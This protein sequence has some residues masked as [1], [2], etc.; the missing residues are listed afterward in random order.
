MIS[1]GTTLAARSGVRAL[2]IRHHVAGRAASP[3]AA[4][5]YNDPLSPKSNRRL[6]WLTVCGWLRRA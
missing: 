3:F 2:P 6:V 1:S 5:D 4:S